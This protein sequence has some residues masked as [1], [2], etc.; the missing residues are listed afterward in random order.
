MTSDNIGEIGIGDGNMVIMEPMI[1]ASESDTEMIGE[2]M[3]II[4]GRFPQVAITF[5]T[6]I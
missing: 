1:E 2:M 5:R 3:E 6:R 4:Q